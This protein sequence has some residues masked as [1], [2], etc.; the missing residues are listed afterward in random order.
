MTSVIGV[1]ADEDNI[2]TI[3]VA[4]ITTMFILMATKL[5]KMPTMLLMSTTM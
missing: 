1:D 2:N 5:M 4:D 3:M